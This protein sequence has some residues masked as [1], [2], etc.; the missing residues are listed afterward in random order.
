MMTIQS[1]KTRSRRDL[2]ALFKRFRE[3]R[4]MSLQLAATLSDGDATAQSMPDASPAKWHLAH[5]SWF[6]EEFVVA[7]ILGDGARFDSAYAYLFNSY[8]DAVGPRHTRAER[9][10]LTR[11]RLE[12]IFAYRAH[13]DAAIARLFEAG[14]IADPFLIELGVNHEQQH[15]ELLLTDILHLFAQNPLRPVF[16]RSEP[17]S[18]AENGSTSLQWIEFDGGVESVGHDSTDFAFDCEG[19]VHQVLLRPYKLAN[20]AVTNAEWIA[21]I[22]DGGYTNPALCLSDGLATATANDWTHPLYWER[23]DGEWW[24]MTLRGFQPVD[25]AAP[26]AH[27]SFYEADAF[28][29][30]AGARLPME[31]EWEIAA[32]TCSSVG[33]TLGSGRLRPA[34][35]RRG[36]LHGMFGDVWEW[37]A[38][39]FTPYPGFR[40]ANGAVGEYNGKFMSGQMVLRGGSCVT[41]DGH[42]RGTYRNFFHPDKRWQFSGL[43]LAK[44]I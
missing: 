3:T 26:V 42:L 32:R 43:R 34:P 14:D 24:S 1:P 6:F 12:D 17:L 28:A 31:Q 39:P 41:P 11:P 13:V 16:K 40:P 8:Y 2:A 30:W 5:T 44:D 18:V 25:P 37:T 33:N 20:R 21:F 35:Q 38:S 22:E 15:Q 29:S 36:A 4:E 7:P 23:R 10:I 27:V 19:P 9:G